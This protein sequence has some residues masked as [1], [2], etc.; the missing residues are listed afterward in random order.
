MQRWATR[1]EHHILGSFRACYSFF[2][3]RVK[4][5]TD[6]CCLHLK[7]LLVLSCLG[8]RSKYLPLVNWSKT[9][10][11]SQFIWKHPWKSPL[12]TL[13]VMDTTTTRRIINTWYILFFCLLVAVC[14]FLFSTVP[15]SIFSSQFLQTFLPWLLY[16]SVIYSRWY[17]NNNIFISLSDP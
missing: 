1:I 7:A 14:C 6:Q 8:R 9:E 12:E 17:N 3:S 11:M 15:N 2:L 16:I 13:L 10:S 4:A 5:T